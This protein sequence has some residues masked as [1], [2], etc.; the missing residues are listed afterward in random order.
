VAFLVDNDFLEMYPLGKDQVLVKG[1]RDAVGCQI[2]PAT[3][4]DPVR[5][6]AWNKIGWTAARAEDNYLWYISSNDGSPHHWLVGLE[7]SPDM[8]LPPF[9]LK[10]PGLAYLSPWGVYRK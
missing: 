2:W 5:F 8:Y 9:Q 7:P 1:M 10:F 3:K 6:F 4:A